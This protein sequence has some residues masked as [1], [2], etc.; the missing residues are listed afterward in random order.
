MNSTLPAGYYKTAWDGANST[1]A[2]IDNGVYFYKLSSGN[3]EEVT[4][5][6]V[7]IR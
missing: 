2:R 4:G 5:K 1:G 7:L 6:V 3:G